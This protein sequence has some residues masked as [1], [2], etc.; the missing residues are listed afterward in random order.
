MANPYK[1]RFKLRSLIF[2]FLIAYGKSDDD[3][4]SKDSE[5]KKE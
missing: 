3:D 1:V 2:N 4:E 5:A